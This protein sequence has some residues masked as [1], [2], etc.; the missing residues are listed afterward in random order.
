MSIRR[1]TWKRLG[2]SFLLL[3][4]TLLVASRLVVLRSFAKLQEETVQQEVSSVLTGLSETL[5]DLASTASNYAGWDDTLAF[6]RYQNEDY[7]REN[8]SVKTLMNLRINVVLFLDTSGRVVYGK[9]VGLDAEKDNPVPPDLLRRIS[10]HSSPW[11]HTSTDPELQGIV[12]S[13]DGPMFL[14]SHPISIPGNEG[15]EHVAGV[16][17]VG[18]YL[19]AAEIERLAA[20]AHSTITLRPYDDVD[21]PA[22][23]QEACSALSESGQIVVQLLNRQLAAGYALLEDIW[24]QPSALLKVSVPRTVYQRGRTTAF[25]SGVWVLASCLAFAFL[26]LSILDRRGLSPLSRRGTHL[27]PRDK[28]P[29]PALL[30]PVDQRGELSS[31]TGK[32]N[33]LLRELEL[34]QREQQEA[35]IR[36]RAIVED[37]PELICRF[38]ID[39]TLTY[40]NEAYCRYFEKPRDELVGSSFM[41]LL[42]T[43]DVATAKLH[44]ASLDHGNPIGT[45]EHPV[46]PADPD[47]VVRWLRWNDRAIYDDQGM[48]CEF[49][50]VGRDVTDQRL[51]GGSPQGERDFIDDVLETLGALVIVLDSEGRIVRFNRSCQQMTGYSFVEVRERHMWDFLPAPEEAG[52]VK[53]VFEEVKACRSPSRHQNYIVTKEGSRRLIYWSNTVLV[54]KDEEIEYVIAAGIDITERW[55]VGEE[56]S[57]EQEPLPL[58]LANIPHYV[59]WKDTQLVYLGCNEKFAQAAGVGKPNRIV[60]KTDYDLAWNPAEAD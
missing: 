49:Q 55:N 48:L 54:G 2:L 19:D 21:L 23:S 12:F 59:F 44:L 25:R 60:G 56:L 53:D 9:S 57:D 40:V 50:S 20:R 36:Y 11:E 58:V 41:D 51:T 29:N 7:V 27:D 43:E 22:D 5:Y 24:G 3:A 14:A 16:V 45:R 4:G 47:G 37:R 26:L 15:P 17:L 8:L 28:E 33:G 35:E 1:R 10:T 42:S 6:L 31:L 46:P 34:S 30:L 32:I 38:L 52:F 18:R 39:G 13:A